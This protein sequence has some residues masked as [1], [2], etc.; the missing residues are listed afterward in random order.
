MDHLSDLDKKEKESSHDHHL[1]TC[2]MEEEHMGQANLRSRSSRTSARLAARESRIN[3]DNFCGGA[4]AS[5]V[6][7]FPVEGNKFCRT[8]VLRTVILCVYTIFSSV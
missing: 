5:I 6:L 2:V 8:D 4:K 7:P 3:S 1:A